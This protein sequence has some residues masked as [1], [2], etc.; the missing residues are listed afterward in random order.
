VLTNVVNMWNDFLHAAGISAKSDPFINEDRNRIISRDE[1]ENMNF[2]TTQG[3]AFELRAKLQKYNYEK[4]C[5]EP[6]DLSGNKISFTVYDPEK[7]KAEVEM[8]LT[9]PEGKNYV[10][11]VELDAEENAEYFSL[12]DKAERDEYAKKVMARRGEMTLHSDLGDLPGPANLIVKFS[13]LSGQ[14]Q[15]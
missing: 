6:V 5:P 8:Q 2:V 10:G 4:G 3:I 15:D 9:S 12:K 13:Q 1:A 11:S 7:M 14:P